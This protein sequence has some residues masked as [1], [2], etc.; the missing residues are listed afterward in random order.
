MTIL[1]PVGGRLHHVP[2]GQYVSVL[3]NPDTGAGR[4]R[5]AAGRRVGHDDGHVTG[6]SERE[7]LRCWFGCFSLS[8]CET[9]GCEEKD[10]DE[11]LHTPH[12]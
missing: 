5:H 2:A 9:G 7:L 3:T 12:E 11:A 6:V 1:H 8:E 10:S 4:F